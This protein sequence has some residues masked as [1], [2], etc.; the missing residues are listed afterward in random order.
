[1]AITKRIG[2]R[3]ATFA[4]TTDFGTRDSYVA[5]M[6]AGLLARCAGC[7]VVDVTHEVPRHD[8][9]AGAVVLERALSAFA[10]GTV[11]VA[12][13]DPG[14]GSKRRIL[15]AEINDQ[16]VVCPDNGLIGWALARLGGRV[17]ELTWRPGKA[18][19]TFH[20]RDI[21]VPA[22]A[23]LGQGVHPSELARPVGDPVLID[24]LVPA[25][26]KAKAVRGVVIYVDTYG[27]CV[28]NIPEGLLAG[29]AKVRVGRRK[30]GVTR[31]SYAEVK[32][33]EGVG[34]VGSAGLLEIAVREGSAAEELGIAVGDAVVLG[35]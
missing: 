15:L 5:E 20:G 26:R 23:L 4:L 17:F 34:L 1:M 2:S 32:R 29:V 27:N 31:G 21:M 24:W 12:V 6:K 35:W 10:A 28:T 3:T 25:R 18:S 8:V 19:R 9:V 30:L 11:H 14:V 16:F 13:V 22:A 7:V 33:G